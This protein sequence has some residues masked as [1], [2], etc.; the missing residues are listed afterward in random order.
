MTLCRKTLL[1]IAA[2]AAVF[3]CCLYQY[4]RLAPTLSYTGPAAPSYI[5]DAGHG[6][7]D[8]GALTAEGIPESGLN[9]AIVLKMDQLFGFLGEAPLLLRREDIS[10]HNPDA[11]TLRE[12]KNSDL[13][14]RA[15]AVRACPEATL[16]SIHQN[17]YE[18]EQYR[19]AQV[20]Y[21]PTKGSAQLAQLVQRGIAQYLQ[22]DNTRVEK[23]ISPDI[24]LLNHIENRALLIECGFLSNREE[25]L[26]LMG[27]DYQRRLAAVL[28]WAVMQVP[29]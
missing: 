15:E 27:E 23:P 21:P 22:Q 24:Y 25:A 7:E 2:A 20:F 19:G 11:V 26:L 3:G 13:K 14:N 28:V 5:L 8:G 18:Q 29:D 1:R 4:N 12:K 6:G 16:I 9:L 10:L 17:S